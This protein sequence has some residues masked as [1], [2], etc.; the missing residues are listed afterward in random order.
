M[1]IDCVKD[2]NDLVI[3]LKSAKHI[4]HSPMVQSGVL[5]D[6]GVDCSVISVLNTR[7]IVRDQLRT[8]E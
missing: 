8:L 5:G 1:C 3:R 2:F 4:A 7:T 6:A